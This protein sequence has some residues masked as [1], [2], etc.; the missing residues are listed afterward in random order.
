MAHNEVSDPQ[1]LDATMTFLVASYGFPAV[2]ASLGRACGWA[3]H[4]ARA[5]HRDEDARRW[6]RAAYVVRWASF[7]HYRE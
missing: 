5:R 6:H 7:A 3:E 2:L 1:D 4:A